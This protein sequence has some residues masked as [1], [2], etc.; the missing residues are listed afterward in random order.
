MDSRSGGAVSPRSTPGPGPELNPSGPSAIATT[1]NASIAVG[2]LPMSCDPGDS[3]AVAANP[4]AKSSRA[5]AVAKT[6]VPSNQSP[7]IIR[8]VLNRRPAS[9]VKRTRD[10]PTT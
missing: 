7:S 4:A 1:S 5:A 10:V 3:A 2:G 8:Q 6:Y 9:W